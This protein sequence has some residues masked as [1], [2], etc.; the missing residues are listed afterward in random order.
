MAIFAIPNPKKSLTVDFPLE[1]VKKGVNNLNL[2]S[3]KYKFTSYV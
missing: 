3:N 1:Q 2:I